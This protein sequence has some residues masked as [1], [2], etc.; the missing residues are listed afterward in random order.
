MNKS[1]KLAQAKTKIDPKAYLPKP[2]PTKEIFTRCGYPA[3][4]VARY[5]G[6]CST[7]VQSMLRGEH[8]ISKKIDAKLW[9]LAQAVESEFCRKE[10]R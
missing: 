1:L 5:L 9:E 2:H 4:A 7:Y 10:A 8:R 3:V 6:L